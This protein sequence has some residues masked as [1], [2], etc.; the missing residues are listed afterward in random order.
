MK[1]CTACG[2]LTSRTGGRCTT[3]AR[4]S[5]RSRHNALY[6]TRAWQRLSAR[7]LRAWRGQHGNWC[8]AYPVSGAPA[9]D[10]VRTVPWTRVRGVS[11]DRAD[12]PI[13]G[14]SGS[15]VR[16]AATPLDGISSQMLAA[17]RQADVGVN[18][19]VSTD[20]RDP[21]GGRPIPRPANAVILALVAA[22]YDVEQRRGRG[23]VLTHV[24]SRRPAA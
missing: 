18:G 11:L 17:S 4:Q 24:T 19:S 22:L 3:H 10:S 1:L 16:T 2:V 7:V 6:S 14:V 9:A 13:R 15:T 12:T 21:E 5:N 20:R 23:K 8:P